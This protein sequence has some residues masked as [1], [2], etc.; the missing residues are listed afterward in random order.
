MDNHGETGFVRLIRRIL[1]RI[2]ILEDKPDTAGPK[3]DNAVD[4]HEATDDEESDDKKTNQQK[5]WDE[6][7]YR[8]LEIPV[9]REAPPDHAIHPMRS[10]LLEFPNNDREPWDEYDKLYL[11]LILKP[12]LAAIKAK[13]RQAESEFE[14]I[15]KDLDAA[16]DVNDAGVVH[17][18]AQRR[19][20]MEA[21]ATRL[22]KHVE[23]I[24]AK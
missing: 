2:G 24:E 1:I 10:K 21:R 4:S 8:P 7:R 19:C 22:K 3:S 18:I 15:D 11:Q 6:A 12:R 17:K 23:L 14:Q 9:V 5:E 13:L 16:L 20:V